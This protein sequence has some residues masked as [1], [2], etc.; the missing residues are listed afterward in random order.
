M[1]L[2]GTGAGACD[3]SAVR[4]RTSASRLSISEL[5]CRNG[6]APVARKGAMSLF[7]ADNFFQLEIEISS[8]CSQKAQRWR[9][10]MHRG[11]AP[12]REKGAGPFQYFSAASISVRH[13]LT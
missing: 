7:H 11:L 6:P 10:A 13:R 9:R 12:F 3:A 2:A 4:V 5:Y 8:T 1:K